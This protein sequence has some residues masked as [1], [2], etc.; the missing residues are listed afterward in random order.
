MQS[1]PTIAAGNVD[2]LGADADDDRLAAAQAR[3]GRPRDNALRNPGIDAG[4]LNSKSGGFRRFSRRR[5]GRLNDSRL[6][7]M[8]DA[9]IDA[10]VDAML[11]QSPRRHQLAL[12]V[13]ITAPITISRNLKSLPIAL[14]RLRLALAEPANDDVSRLPFAKTNL[15]AGRRGRDRIASLGRAMNV[16]KKEH[17]NGVT[18]LRIVRAQPFAQIGLAFVELQLDGF[19]RGIRQTLVEQHQFTQVGARDIEIAAR[20]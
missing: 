20:E 5:F 8:V 10:V 18:P 6:N 2:P 19:C 9:V 7:L 1:S 12:K 11:D 15:K 3:G 17:R 13:T 14:D 4:T 16:A